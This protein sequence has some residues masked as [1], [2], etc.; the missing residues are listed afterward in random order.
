MTRSTISAV[1]A[2]GMVIAMWRMNI[3]EQLKEVEKRRNCGMRL[4]AD[5]G[6]ACGSV[7]SG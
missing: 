1:E 4:L 6:V 5:G 2:R 7:A 3:E